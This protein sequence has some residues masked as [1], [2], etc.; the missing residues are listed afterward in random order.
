M[1]YFLKLLFTVVF[2]VFV[3]SFIS[4]GVRAADSIKI[5]ITDDTYAEE[6]YPTVAPWNNRNLFLG[7][8]D[9][10]WK[11]RNRIYLH[12]PLESLYSQGITGADIKTASI[13]LWQYINYT[14]AN[15]T[16]LWGDSYGVWS[17][18]SLTWLSQPLFLEQGHAILTSNIDWQKFDI[19]EYLKRKIS[20]GDS[21]LGI[22]LQNQDEYYYGG[23]FWSGACY[24]APNPPRCDIWQTP[25]LDVVLVPNNPPS[26]VNLL[27]PVDSLITNNGTIE[28]SWTE[29]TDVDGDSL[30]YGLE[31]SR[32][33]T[34]TT[35]VIS[36][37]D[38]STTFTTK[39][40]GVSGEYFWRVFSQDIRGS[41]S[42]KTFS[43][44]GLF[45]LDLEK[46]DTPVLDDEPPFSFGNINTVTWTFNYLN[47]SYGYS[48]LIEHSIVTES[49]L[50]VISVTNTKELGYKFENLEQSKY[51]YR[52][53]S[54]DIAGNESD[55]SEMT[56]S[57]QDYSVPVIS[58]LIVSEEYISPS[59]SLGVKDFSN[60]SFSISELNINRWLLVVENSKREIVYSLEGQESNFLLSF[61]NNNL[62][63]DEGT[64]F[65]Y[66]TVQDYV[67]LQSISNI[68]RLVVDDSVPEP[69]K[70]IT[71]L[72]NQLSNTYDI[73]VVAVTAINVKSLTYINDSIFLESNEPYIST[74]LSSKNV[75]EGKN[76]VRIVSSDFAGNSVTSEQVFY[77]DC[78]SPTI[79]D[80]RL[81]PNYDNTSL[82]FNIDASDFDYIDIYSK[83]GVVKR[84]SLNSTIIV[85]HWSGDSDY[86]YA[87]VAVDRAGNRSIQSSFASFHT[88]KKE[89]LGIGTAIEPGF[90]YP[91]SVG[92][93]T[94]I[95]TRNL[96]NKTIN[97]DSCNLKAPVFA[98]VENH[99]S[100][101]IKYILNAYSNYSPQ[102]EIII[103]DVE[104]KKKT[105][106]DFGTWFKC[107]EVQLNLSSK[108]VD[109]NGD[110]WLKVE[111]EASRHYHRSISNA[112]N[113]NTLHLIKA[114]MSGKEATLFSEV[115]LSL[116]LNDGYWANVFET[117]GDSNKI[118]VDNLIY[119]PYSD[120]SSKYFRFPF[121]NIVGVTQWHGFTAF[122]SPH[123]GIDFGSYLEPIYA[124]AD[125]YVSAI[126]WDNY[127][128]ECFSGGNYI[129][130]THDNG[131]STFFAH[132]ENYHKSD[133]TNWSYGQRVHK[134]ELLGVTGNSGSWNCQPLG[135]HLHFELRQD[136]WQSS[137][138]NP[139]NYIAVDWM[140]VPT[141]NADYIPGRLSG[142][143][144]HPTY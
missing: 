100:D 125:G 54:I 96:T 8:D 114:D 84:I 103:K 68:V 60:I 95:F 34:F 108:K 14:G 24:V 140:Q 11:Q 55:W 32:D 16:I 142:D 47:E 120:N 101:Q 74:L 21:N 61:P 77:V 27:S 67:G 144:P 112:V 15:Y 28:F 82:E 39:E 81:T 49:S 126:G 134:G 7:W 9:Q 48:F 111:G 37:N 2:A 25:Y 66:L 72:S 129:K 87:A 26:E 40:I 29:S 121:N 86:F 136:L 57:T 69:A 92:I 127:Y 105:F 107:K 132:L 12:I 135:Y 80:V 6:G 63:L 106:W 122:D 31:I 56:C 139:V 18:Y 98:K 33:R 59:N 62:L 130:I 38:I 97:K 141:L 85:D 65:V 137:H 110:I 88:P 102:V 41:F 94:C 23:V 128:G 76:V 46:P 91:Q 44:T 133:G 143:N 45:I 71:P 109:T 99:T 117:T 3:L 64:Y 70:F 138:I 13:N 50:T 4:V 119:N 5:G 131:M 89:V 123:T 17:Q 52:V 83:A 35:D 20:G 36:I 53:K 113:T 90:Q 124:M 75:V 58:S 51:C 118:L 1:R 30:I 22:I 10:Y 78:T 116:N 42:K 104:C 79:Y 19:T 93:S 115:S 73:G 43:K